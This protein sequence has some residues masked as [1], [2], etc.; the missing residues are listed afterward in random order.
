MG[1]AASHA[2]PTPVH[3][4]PEAVAP[5]DPMA[6]PLPA[7]PPAARPPDPEVL[8]LPPAPLGPAELVLPARAVAPACEEVVPPAAVLEPGCV[9][10]SLKLPPDVT[11]ASW[12]PEL[13]PGESE[14]HATTNRTRPGTRYR[15]H[16]VRGDSA[17]PRMQGRRRA[18][19]MRRTRRK[20]KKPCDALGRSARERTGQRSWSHVGPSVRSKRERCAAG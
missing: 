1:C 13:P 3:I 16:E 8:G 9:P 17:I 2:V 7:A 18:S 11:P 5:P 12:S 4:P 15:V 14:P 6:V 10:A 19:F 20:R